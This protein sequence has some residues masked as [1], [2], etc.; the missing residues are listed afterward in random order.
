MS[1]ARRA[2]FVQLLC[3]M[4][5]PSFGQ[6]LPSPDGACEPGFFCKS[7]RH[8]P[9]YLDL[10]DRLG[11]LNGSTETEYY[12]NLE[13]KVRERI[14]NKAEDGVCCKESV[15][16]TNGNIVRN[17]EDFPFI[18]RLTIKTGYADYSVC[19]AA[20]VDSQF[21]ITAKHCLKKFYDQ[22]IDETD[23]VAHFRDLARGPTNH[24]SGQFY[25]AITE[26][27]EKAGVSD[28]AVAQLKH[29]VEEHED[30][31]K[32]PPLHPIKIATEEP[33]PGDKVL[34]AGWGLTGYNE[35]LSEELRSL[36]LSITTVSNQSQ[37]LG[38]KVL[39]PVDRTCLYF[40]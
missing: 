17:V 40:F 24:E 2:L 13:R 31:N 27:F 30:Y 16:L 21:L 35:D 19:G 23:C 32:G 38:P 3:I 18:A 25:I 34:T 36:E 33:K 22:C 26:I 28:L 7:E 37:A 14:C 39:G 15:E 8:C 11:R 4:M 5:T 10:R 12:K 1:L 20:L 29:K 9:R 6:Q